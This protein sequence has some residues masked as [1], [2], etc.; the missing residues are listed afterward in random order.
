M[1]LFVSF[2]KRKDGRRAIAWGLHVLLQQALT[3]FA[4]DS[5]SCSHGFA[6]FGCGVG[7]W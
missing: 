6:G 4:E 5:N 3:V 2:L 7:D 1:K